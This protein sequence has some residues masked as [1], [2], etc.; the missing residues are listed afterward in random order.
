LQPGVDPGRFTLLDGWTGSPVRMTEQRRPSPSQR[1]IDAWMALGAG[2][3]VMIGVVHGNVFLWILIGTVAG[4]GLVWPE[5][6]W[7]R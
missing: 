2:L 5:D 4:L 1:T 3:G 6:D 7:K